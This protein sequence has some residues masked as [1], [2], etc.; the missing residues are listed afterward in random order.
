LGAWRQLADAEWLEHLFGLFG[1]LTIADKVPAEE[2]HSAFREID[3]HRAV[4]QR[5]C[6]DRAA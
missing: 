6:D 2:V 5:C 4:M 1:S 3:E